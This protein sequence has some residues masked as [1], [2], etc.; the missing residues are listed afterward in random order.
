MFTYFIYLYKIIYKFV[1][2]GSKL[3]VV[4]C[5]LH[6]NGVISLQVPESFTFFTGAN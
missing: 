6:I 5:D 1:S 2:C 4:I 3:S